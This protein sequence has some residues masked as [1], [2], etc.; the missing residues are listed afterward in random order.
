ME[1]A[2]ACP[3]S[4]RAVAPSL[5]AQAAP[6]GAAVLHWLLVLL[7][8]A[9]QVGA[10]PQ[11]PPAPSSAG[12]CG[13]WSFSEQPVRGCTCGLLGNDLSWLLFSG[14]RSSSAWALG[15]F[16]LILVLIFITDSLEEV[17][18]AACDMKA[19][20]RSCCEVSSGAAGM[21]CQEV[22]HLLR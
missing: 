12:P 20:R 11:L 18:R 4:S 17:D 5:T 22:P 7:E 6:A 1:T 9:F 15:L 16:T 2:R 13:S 3:F 10:P 14:C 21:R 8:A 19:R